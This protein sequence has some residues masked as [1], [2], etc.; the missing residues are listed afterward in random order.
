MAT[1]RD[2]VGRFL[3]V[4]EH[5]HD[6]V[7]TA[8]VLVFAVATGLLAGWIT[9]DFGVRLPAFLA[10]AVGSAYLLYGRR[11]RRTVVA[12]GLYALAA[13]FALAPLTFELA[14]VLNVDEPLR[15]VLSVTDLY[16]VLAFWLLAAVPAVVGYRVATGP[17]LPR[18]RGLV[19]G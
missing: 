4:F 9:A 14:T 7:T 18:I 2:R 16:V 3:P 8:V 11:T 12:A 17:F 15:H 13:L 19:S 5:T 1:D 6:P 10:G